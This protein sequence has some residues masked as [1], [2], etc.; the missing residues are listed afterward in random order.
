MW[1]SRSGKFVVGKL[2][3]FSGGGPLWSKF[4]TYN[5]DKANKNRFQ[6]YFI[7][8]SKRNSKETK[9]KSKHGIRYSGS[10]LV[11]L[12]FPLTTFVPKVSFDAKGTPVSELR[13][14]PRN[15]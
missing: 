5:N 4:N 9:K 15:E 10:I 6:D 8:W 13:V 14:I 1:V 11:L 12:N 3:I 7:L 2:D